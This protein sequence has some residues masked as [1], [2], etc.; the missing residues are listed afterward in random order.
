MV[1]MVNIILAKHQ[2]GSIV[3]VSM[4]ATTDPYHFYIYFTLL[5]LLT[6]NKLGTS[7]F[8]IILQFCFLLNEYYIFLELLAWL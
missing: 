5:C 2:H 1:N 4:L 3:F 6:L 7:T 8:N